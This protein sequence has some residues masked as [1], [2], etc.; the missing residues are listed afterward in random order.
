ME[1]ILW[2]DLSGYGAT[3]SVA[4]N[5]SVGRNF[6]KFAVNDRKQF[7]RT[8]GVRGDLNSLMR[9]AGFSLCAN[10]TQVNQARAYGEA[11]REGLPYDAVEQ[12]QREAREAIFFYSPTLT[13]TRD[14]IRI[15]LPALLDSDLRHVPVSDV[16]HFDFQFLDD[17]TTRTFIR[18]QQAIPGA[19]PGVFFTT[20]AD[21]ELAA[22]LGESSHSL[23]ELLE[24]RDL[25]PASSRDVDFAGEISD[26]LTFHPVGVMERAVRR[27]TIG[28]DGMPLRAPGMSSAIVGYA[29][30]DAAI[31][32]NGD[33]ADGVEAVELPYGVPVGFSV[34][35]ARLLVLKDARFLEFNPAALPD[36]DAALPSNVQRN[37]DFLLYVALVEAEY[38]SLSEEG[39]L[40]PAVWTT[41]DVA[42]DV[43]TR[44]ERIFWQ[45]KTALAPVMPHQGFFTIESI[46]LYGGQRA[47]RFEDHY[48]S[49]FLRFVDDF[50]TNL[51]NA[52][53]RAHEELMAAATLGRVLRSVAAAT[54]PSSRREDAGEKIG[55]ARKDYALRA[56]KRTEVAELS[57]RE[58][59]DIVTKE[60]VW[61]KP[62][63]AGMRERGVEPHVA[64][65]IREFRNALPA[66]PARGGRNRRR[67][68]LEKRALEELGEERCDWFIRS[69]ELVRD[70]L[71]D[72]QT[73]EDLH[74]A[75]LAIREQ[76][77]LPVVIKP[78]STDG[79][80]RLRL[81]SGSPENFF[82]RSKQWFF[83]GAGQRFT[84]TVLP[85]VV[86]EEASGEAR[87]GHRLSSRLEA[88]RAS[89]D[90][91]WGWSVKERATRESAETVPVEKITPVPLHL[92]QIRRVGP[93]VRN[94][95][96]VDEAQLM[97]VFGFR[98]IEYGKWLP[99]GERQL[100]LNHAYDAFADLAEALAMPARAMSLSGELAIAFGARGHGG[101]EA[102]AAHYEP[103]RRVFNLTRLS[104]AGYIAHE[105]WH[106]FDDWLGRASGL[107]TGYYATELLG[108]VRA[109]RS[110]RMP[111]M[112]SIVADLGDLLHQAK[113]VAMPLEAVLQQ[114]ATV[115]LDDLRV[116][117]D[118][119]VERR[120]LDWI[121]TLDRMLPAERRDS[122]FRD[123]AVGAMVSHWVD[124]PDIESLSLRRFTDIERYVQTVCDAMDVAM[125]SAEWRERAAMYIAHPPLTVSMQDRIL[126]KLTSVRESYSPED[127]RKN[128]T[129]FNDAL[130]YD[131]KRSKPYWSTDVELSARGFET[132]VQ[133]RVQAGGQRRSDYLVHGRDDRTD[134]P[135]WGYPRGGERS[136]TASALSAYF[137]RHRPELVKLL[138]DVPGRNVAAP[139]S[140]VTSDAM[141]P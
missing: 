94:G 2:P 47:A 23:N 11:V 72:V 48:A 27:Q 104:G 141:E 40:D 96:D 76:A 140:S 80:S 46:A 18:Q 134:K 135:H 51:Y 126:K 82:W 105:W 1:S 12:A 138:E 113:T 66:N 69:V 92:D 67:D 79:E 74:R 38:V 118:R 59:I 108:K 71:A 114:H 31:T 7:E 4:F 55:G 30:R 53:Q 70:S 10:E 95:L 44:F 128:S 139:V 81:H 112:P 107:S 120:L 15:F 19:M 115:Q 33:V 110:V 34:P 123:L 106:A 52:A 99:Q 122:S 98:A 133:D 124:V 20:P 119:F 121:S 78:T 131:E 125:G 62:D 93:D 29:T 57:V 36:L 111:P 24:Y 43:K 25:P 103:A 22:T 85:D 63:L 97:E 100:V 68:F 50:R 87:A 75:C 127:F 49:D 5:P 64:F 56:L 77:D 37:L 102:A 86:V 41:V 8:S 90:G 54:Q 39:L 58:R 17:E 109:R 84:D 73:E 45:M 91:G 83:D 42:G 28:I 136:A 132:W 117:V 88:A 61:P 6:L 137:D 21:R 14:R 89:T 65:V 26:V 101:K 32:A 60:N 129:F 3:L 130:F 9:Q 16:K 35:D 13:F 116:P